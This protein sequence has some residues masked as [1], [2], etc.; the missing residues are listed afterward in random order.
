MGRAAIRRSDATRVDAVVGAVRSVADTHRESVQQMSVVHPKRVRKEESP[1]VVRLVVSAAG[2]G[3][4]LGT[5]PG[6]MSRGGAS[7]TPPPGT[8]FPGGCL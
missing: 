3:G 7:K 1:P 8:G 2:R 6:T 4:F 5:P